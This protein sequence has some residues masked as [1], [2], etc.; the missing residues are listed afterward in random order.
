MGVRH[1]SKKIISHRTDIQCDSGLCTQLLEWNRTP[2]HL[3]KERIVNLGWLTR[4]SLVFCPSCAQ[5][6]LRL[7]LSNHFCITSPKGRCKISSINPEI[8]TILLARHLI[9]IRKGGYQLTE[10]G[11]AL[12][13]LKDAEIF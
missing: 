7:Y 6:Q 4:G 3:V 5:S 8:S 9:E 2:V 1:Y 13:Q 12:L 11:L 10:K